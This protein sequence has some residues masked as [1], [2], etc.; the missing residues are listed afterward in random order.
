[1]DAYAQAWLPLVALSAILLGVPAYLL[2][3]RP[4]RM[5][6]SDLS[7]DPVAEDLKRLRMEQFEARVETK[8]VE[9]AQRRSEELAAREGGHVVGIAAGTTCIT[10]DGGVG[11]RAAPA[12]A[13]VVF[14]ARR[15]ENLHK[16]TLD[17]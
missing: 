5:E 2:L 1:M 4:H 11:G 13:K 8:R 12:S 15:E 3:H 16:P 17:R 7:I 6:P 14:S 9:T 10:R